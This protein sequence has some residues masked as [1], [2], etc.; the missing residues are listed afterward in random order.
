MLDIIKAK[1]AEQQRIPFK[2]DQA[3]H[4][5]VRSTDQVVQFLDFLDSSH[6]QATNKELL[7]N[8]PA[9]LFGKTTR[10]TKRSLSDTHNTGK[11]SHSYEVKSKWQQGRLSGD[12]SAVI[13][14]INMTNLRSK[15]KI[16]Q[17]DRVVTGPRI[18]VRMLPSLSSCSLK[19]C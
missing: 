16:L 14:S 17:S 9:T 2:K 6:R 18:S 13:N 7:A 12:R 11:Y 4:K 5:Y 8:L 3:Y 1:K 19:V 10:N 15:H